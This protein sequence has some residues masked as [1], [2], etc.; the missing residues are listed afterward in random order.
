VPRAVRTRKVAPRRAED[1]VFRAL[2]DANR[3]RILLVLGAGEARVSDIAAAFAVSR[4]AISK[5][6]AVLRRA[7]LVTARKAGRERYYRIAPE[8]LRSASGYAR[9][10]EGFWREGLARLDEKLRRR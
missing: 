4:P 2:A 1:A 10:V 7:G 5:Q 3:R 6:L 9:D 8:A